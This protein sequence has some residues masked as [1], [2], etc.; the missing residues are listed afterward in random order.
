MNNYETVIVIDAHQPEEIIEGLVDKIKKLITDNGGEILDMNRWG[1]RRLA[2][3]IRK[4]QHGYYICFIFEIDKN[5]FPS[6]LE[7]FFRLNEEILR[8]LILR[9]E[10]KLLDIKLKK[11]KPEKD[12]KKVSSK[13]TKTENIEKEEEKKVVEES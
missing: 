7:R 13:D 5:N 1:K 9:L 6:V 8:Y 11:K 12:T 3:E 10:K 4:K 2:Y